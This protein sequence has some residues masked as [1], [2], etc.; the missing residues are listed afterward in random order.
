MFDYV[1]ILEHQLG[2]FYTL[3][4]LF[5]CGEIRIKPVDNES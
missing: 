2:D 1:A 5:S 4:G 3:I